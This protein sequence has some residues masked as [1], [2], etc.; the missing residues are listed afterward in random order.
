MMMCAASSPPTAG[1]EKRERRFTQKVY[2]SRA[3]RS[4][5]VGSDTEDRPLLDL[6]NSSLFRAL[7]QTGAEVAAS[8]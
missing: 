8:A 6:M 3:A 1:A 4:V 5:T 7:G 2:G